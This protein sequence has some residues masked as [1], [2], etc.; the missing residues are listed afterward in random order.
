M[1]M[2][3]YNIMAL[4][5][6][7]DIVRDNEYW[8]SMGASNILSKEVERRLQKTGLVSCGKDEWILDDCIEIKEYCYEEFFQGFEMKGCLSYFEQGVELCYNFIKLFDEDIPL[9]IVI[10]NQ[11]VKVE[12]AQQLFALTKEMYKD[13]FTIFQKQYN[14]VHLKAT[15]GKFYEIMR[16]RSKWY[17][18]LLNLKW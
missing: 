16:K 18:K 1:G 13:K 2:E 15:S 3:S 10:F 4:S 5:R 12:N 14:N 9:K 8:H 6:E 17:Y 11:E 7:V